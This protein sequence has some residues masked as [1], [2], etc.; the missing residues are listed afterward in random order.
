ML[1]K[2]ISNLD[3]MLLPDLARDIEEEFV[4]NATS[5]CA[6][7]ELLGLDP[8][9]LRSNVPDPRSGYGMRPLFTRRPCGP[10]PSLHWRRTWIAY[11][12]LENVTPGF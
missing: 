1:P 4:F 7:P 5:T 12:R 8:I 3:E 2:G 11:S 9:G 6:A 10:S